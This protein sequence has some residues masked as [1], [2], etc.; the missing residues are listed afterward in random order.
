MNHYDRQYLK[1]ALPAALEGL[2]M[3]L[4]ASTDLILVGALGSFSVAAVSIF[5]QPRLVLLCLSRSLASAV[6]LVVARLAGKEDREAVAALLKKSLFLCALV[7]GILHILCFFFLEPIFL[8]MGA[9]MDYMAEALDYGGPALLSVYFT[10]LALILQAVQLGYGD[11]ASIMKTNIAGNGINGA[12]SFVLISGMGPIPAFGVRGAAIGTI[13]GTFFTLM[14]SFYLLNRRGFF[15]GGSFLPDRAYFRTVLPIFGS[16]LGEQGSERIGMVLFSRMAA[17]LGTVPFAVHSICMNICDVY[18]DF[19][20]GFGKAGM[21]AAG[22]SV[23][24]GSQ[25]DWTAYRNCGLKWCLILSAAVCGAVL[26][27]SDEIFSFYSKEPDLLALSGTVMVI[28]AIVSFPEAL[29]IWGAGILRGSGK[30][31][32]VAAYSFLSITFL[33][34]LVTAFFLYVLD[35]GLLGTWCALLLDQLIRAGCATFLVGRLSARGCS[36]TLAGNGSRVTGG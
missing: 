12:L 23:G 11:T 30:T 21:V 20:M 22:Q 35:M 5:L 4:L 27:F 15:S 1:I 10:S 18:Y 24:R 14:A 13:V 26:L 36:M 31:A 8:L 34:P 33:R 3:I 9:S 6:T 2:F 17:G 7:M 32:Q 16:I 25:S 29:A 19:I 28:I